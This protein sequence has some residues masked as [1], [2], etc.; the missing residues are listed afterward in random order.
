[1]GGLP[2][3]NAR[4][5]R[6]ARAAVEIPLLSPSL[7]LSVDAASAADFPKSARLL[8]FKVPDRNGRPL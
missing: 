1:M 6:V 2:R 3:S 4:S 7:H 5:A 8:A